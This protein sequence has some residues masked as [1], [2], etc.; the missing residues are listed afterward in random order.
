MLPTRY[1]T[2]LQRQTKRPFVVPFYRFKLQLLCKLRYNDDACSIYI[3]CWHVAWHDSSVYLACWNV[4]IRFADVTI[5]RLCLYKYQEMIE[6]HQIDETA[7]RIVQLHI[8]I[9][10]YI[11][12]RYNPFV[13]YGCER[14]LPYIHYIFHWHTH[15]YHGLVRLHGNK[16]LSNKT[17]LKCVHVKFTYS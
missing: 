8:H 16:Q 11:L 4:S 5:F 12:V 7:N 10:I 15:S 3:Y 6:K 14:A 9:Y 17:S 13:F 2:R 1:Y